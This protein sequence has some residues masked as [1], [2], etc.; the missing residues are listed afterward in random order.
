MVR[1]AT[2]LAAYRAGEYELALRE[3]RTARRLTG[4]QEHLPVMADCERGLGRPQRALEV[5]ASPEA[6][7]LDRS[8]RLELLMVAAG[9]RLDLGQAD[10][11]VV[12]LQVPELERGRGQ[13]A[14]RLMSAYADALEAAGR[15][16]EA[17]A[18]LLRAAEQDEDGST[19][20]AER[21]GFMEP[22]LITD[23]LEDDPL[24][25]PVP[26][27]RTDAGS[28]DRGA[29]SAG[30]EVTSPGG[31]VAGPTRPGAGP[32]PDVPVSGTPDREDSEGATGREDELPGAGTGPGAST[33]DLLFS[34]AGDQPAPAPGRGD[35]GGAGEDDAVEDD[36][37]AGRD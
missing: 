19:G 24:A 2:G 18:W 5:A 16:S 25:D 34:S 12:M 30:P 1:E 10:A 36:E 26:A 4:S 28:D 31:G 22:E 6:A 29:S 14:A 7:T 11:A 13:V 9:A 27:V 15:A 17:R 20:A 21:V 23:L 8:G 37:A 33:T 3:L 32:A 35:E